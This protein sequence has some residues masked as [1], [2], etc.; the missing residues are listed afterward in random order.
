MRPDD[1]LRLGNGVLDTA[2]T[3]L[4]VREQDRVRAELPKEAIRRIALP[5]PEAGRSDDEVLSFLNTSVAPYR[6]GNGHP[7]F[8][9]WIT[10]A[11][12]PIGVLADLLATAT[13][14]NCEPGGHGAAELERTVCHW[15]M[16]L[17]GFPCTGSHGLLVSGGSMANLTALA[18]ARH[19]ACTRAG[20]DVRRDGASATADLVLY[21]SSETHAC[22]VKAVELIGLGRRRVRTI[23]VDGDLRM[24]VDL[25]AEAVRCDRDAGLLPFCVV[26]TA[27]TVNTG[28]IDPLDA[29]ADLCKAEGLWF[30]VDGAYGGIAAADPAL[31]PLSGALARADSLALDPHKWLGVPI[32]C[33]C[34]LIATRASS[35]RPSA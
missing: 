13:N 10:S 22:I 2:A 23:P 8:F 4:N 3:L 21:Q 25:L 6:L 12:A 18:V 16:D 17:T 19:R 7:R 33:G 28:A 15:L 27:G 31:A 20:R 26:G 24:R 14:A 35:T 5:L 11:P 9:G 1:F 29:I 32:E 34:I 30:H